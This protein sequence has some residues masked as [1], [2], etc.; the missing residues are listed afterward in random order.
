MSTSHFSSEG[1]GTP[2]APGRFVDV[3]AIE[4]VEAIPGLEFR[5][6][7]GQNTMT[8][9]VSFPP[10]TRAPMHSHEEE[11]IAIVLDGEFEFQ[12]DDEVRTMRAGDVAVIPPW[13]PHGAWTNDEPSLRAGPRAS[14]SRSPPSWRARACMLPSA[15]ATLTRWP[16]QVRNFAATG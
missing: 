12:I 4:S 15:R 7:I 16:R 3:S 9:F 10:N 13:V 11:Q 14:V 2:T 8:N 6:V 1:Q 5:P